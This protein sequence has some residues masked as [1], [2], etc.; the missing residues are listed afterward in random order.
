VQIKHRASEMALEALRRH[1]LGVPQDA[2]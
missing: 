2:A 1:L